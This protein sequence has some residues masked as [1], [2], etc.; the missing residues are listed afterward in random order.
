MTDIHKLCEN[1]IQVGEF[2]DSKRPIYRDKNC[3]VPSKLHA[4]LILFSKKFYQWD[5]DEEYN[6]CIQ[7]I[8]LQHYSLCGGDKIPQSIIYDQF[9]EALRLAT[10]QPYYDGNTF[11]QIRD[12]IEDEI[13][14]K[15]FWNKNERFTKAEIVDQ[16]ILRYVCQLMMLS[17]FYTGNRYFDKEKGK[18][19]DWVMSINL[20]EPDPK[21]FKCRE[22]NKNKLFYA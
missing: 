3:W 20:P 9:K 1:R 2:I 6:A 13:F 19:N 11:D 15:T 16:L 5:N 12:A 8:F 10:L 22:F 7:A 4:N 14:F 17:V 21:I 18:E